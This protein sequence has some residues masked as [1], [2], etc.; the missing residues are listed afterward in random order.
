MIDDT[1]ND[2][3]GIVR[4]GHYTDHQALRR[5]SMRRITFAASAL[6]M[7]FMASTAQAQFTVGASAGAGVAMGQLADAANT[8]VNVRAMGVLAVPMMPAA[9][10]MELS[11]DRFG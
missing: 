4:Y 2:T 3:T 9:L 1:T 6:G 5:E 8:G 10:E 11:Y 7:A